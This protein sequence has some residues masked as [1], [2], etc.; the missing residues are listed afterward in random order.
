MSATWPRPPGPFDV[1]PLAEL[2]CASENVTGCGQTRMDPYHG[3]V[4]GAGSQASWMSRDEGLALEAAG[5][6]RLAA[7]DRA[8]TPEMALEM[9]SKPGASR[10]KMLRVLAAVLMWR[11]STTEQL[12]AITGV[13][14]R[15]LD[16]CLSA[17]WALGLFNRGRIISHLPWQNFPQLWRVGRKSDLAKFDHYFSTREWALT[18]AGQRWN[19]GSQIDRH[20]LLATE[21]ALRIAEHCP[22]TAVLG[23]HLANLALLTGGVPSTTNR[24]ADSVI[25]RADGALI[26]I[27][28]TASGYRR[29]A[30]KVEAWMQLLAQPGGRNMAVL[31]VDASRP[32]DSAAG[33]H[34]SDA[35]LSAISTTPGVY[36]SG[37]VDRIMIARWR[38]W[39]PSLHESNRTFPSLPAV[40]PSGPAG[41]RWRDVS[42]I[43]PFSLEIEE[44]AGAADMLDRITALYGTPHW[45]QTGPE[46]DV[47]AVVL[48]RAGLAEHPLADHVPLRWRET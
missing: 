26:A 22:T 13:S 27:E 17:G 7:K 6:G 11:T 1:V 2:P 14:G 28:V 30:A 36:Q 15:P 42:V 4:W 38:D 5:M 45:Q 37:A 34:L 10:D 8:M 43:D 20:N 21:L 48:G 29:T 41:D 39:F 46:L 33:E 44:R 35:I 47:S 25:V 19:E 9:L 3:S 31:F 16:R 40:T 18:L 12:A 23:E 32:D 24:Y